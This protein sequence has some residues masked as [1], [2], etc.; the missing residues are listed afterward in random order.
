MATVK[1]SY[2]SLLVA[3]VTITRNR[4]AYSQRKVDVIEVVKSKIE[5]QK[6]HTSSKLLGKDPT[7]PFSVSGQLRW[8]GP[9]AVSPPIS[10]T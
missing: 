3:V 4:L 2:R 5:V 9:V 8:L 1:L 6:V 10:V 7:L